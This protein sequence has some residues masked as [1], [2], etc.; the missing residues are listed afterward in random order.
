MPKMHRIRMATG[1]CPD[2]L[3]SFSAPSDHLAAI[4]GF[5]LLRGGRRGGKGRE[6]GLTPAVHNS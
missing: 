5:L 1:L 4:K 2:P 3:G 6:G